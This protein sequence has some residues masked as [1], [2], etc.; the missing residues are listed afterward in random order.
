MLSEGPISEQLLFLS[1]ANPHKKP[2]ALIQQLLV[3]AHNSLTPQLHVEHRY[4][5]IYVQLH[6]CCLPC[7]A[8][9]FLTPMLVYNCATARR[10][11]GLKT[12]RAGCFA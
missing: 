1:L 11:W 3:M 10:I 9:M 5:Y 2:R 7:F 12:L 8:Y 4:E 6:I